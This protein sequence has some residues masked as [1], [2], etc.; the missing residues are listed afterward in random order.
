MELSELDK[1][2][3]KNA[4]LMKQGKIYYLS[5]DI[6]T[7]LNE[8][9]AKN[10]W[11]SLGKMEIYLEIDSHET[12]FFCDHRIGRV[13]DLTFLSVSIPVSIPVAIPVS[14]AIA[15]S[16]PI[17]LLTGQLEDSDGNPLLQKPT[18]PEVPEIDSEELF[19]STILDNL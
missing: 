4:S 14:V 15:V 6:L 7:K 1:L 11:Q 17:A 13:G 19:Y 16:V 3:R 9:R 18:T 5:E 2:V 8:E 10:G 12:L